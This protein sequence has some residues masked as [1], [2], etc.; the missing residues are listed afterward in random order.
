MWYYAGIDITL[1]FQTILTMKQSAG[2]KW[3]YCRTL[4]AEVSDL[5]PTSDMARLRT[6]ILAKWVYKQLPQR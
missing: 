4:N 5:I 3:V 2:L 1:K 6:R